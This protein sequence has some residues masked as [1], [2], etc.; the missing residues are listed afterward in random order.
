MFLSKIS[1]KVRRSH[2]FTLQE[3]LIVV[4]IVV[5]LAGISIPLLVDMVFHLRM[6]ELDNHAKS[7]YLEAQN[8]MIEKEVEGS[9]PTFYERIKDSYENRFL[10]TQPHD[11]DGEKNGDKWQQ[12]CYL[13]KEDALLAE[14]IPTSSNSYQMDGNYLI[15]LNPQTGDIY[16]VFYWDKN[17][18]LDYTEHILKLLDRTSSERYSIEV[19]YYGGQLE[20]TISASFALEQ[21]VEAVNGEELYFTVSYTN[22]QRLLKY[23]NTALSITYTI[24]DEHENTYEG[25]IFTGDGILGER[26]QYHI[27]LD[28]IEDGYHFSDLY[29]DTLVAGDNLTIRV[30][31]TFKQGAYRCVE[32]SEPIV[33]NSLFATKSGLNEDTIIEFGRL[34]HL[35]NLDERI[36]SYEKDDGELII[37][38]LGDIDFNTVSYS[39][40]DGS[41]EGSG[42]ARPID[43]FAPLKNT[44]IFDNTNASVTTIDGAG[45]AIKNLPIVGSEDYVGFLSTANY[46]NF[47][48]MRLEDISIHASEYDYVGAYAGALTNCNIDNC[49]V[50]LSNYAME[51]GVRKYY[52]DKLYATGAY[53]NEMEKRCVT[54]SVNGDDYVGG[55]AGQMTDCT[56]SSSLS[57]IAV[58]GDRKTGGFAGT[59][60][61]ARVTTSYASGKVTA[62]QD[63]V[64]GFVGEARHVHIEDVYTTSNVIALQ[65]AGG[66]VGYTKNDSV[67]KNCISYGYVLSPDG[68]N[69]PLDAGG[70]V[71]N[72]GSEE[73][74][75]T[76]NNCCFLQQESYNTKDI[77][78]PEAIL[79]KG[80]MTLEADDTNG[81]KEDSTYPYDGN[82]LGKSFPFVPILEV[83]YGD[84][85]V[86]HSI[87]SSLVYFERYANGELDDEYGYYCVT[88]LSDKETA[89]QYVWVLDTL[90]NRECIEDGYAILSDKSF[91]SFSYQLD[92]NS[93]GTDLVRKNLIV[94]ETEH[95]SDYATLMRQQ[96]A[97][98]FQGYT[99]DGLTIH[100]DF[101]LMEP[102]D[103]FS[104]DGMYLYQ[105]PYELQLTARDNTASSTIKNFYDEIVIYNGI[106]K[107]LDV[108]TLG[109]ATPTD[110]ENQVFY[111]C[112][113]FAKNAINAGKI[114][115]VGATREAPDN[116]TIGYVRSARQLNALGRYN[117][118]WNTTKGAYN[119]QFIQEIDINFGTYTKNYCGQ[120][121][122]LMDTSASNPIRN[123]P[124]GQPTG[125]TGG[126]FK[127]SYDGRDNKII[128]YCVS[129]NL[130][131]VGLFGEICSSKICNVIMTV[132]EQGAGYI[133]SNFNAYNPTGIGALAGL[134]YEDGAA[135]ENVIENCSAVGYTVRYKT[136]SGSISTRGV[137]IGGLIGFAMDDIRY[138]TS[139]N[140][141]ILDVKATFRKPVAMG[142]LIGS[143]YYG[144]VERSYTGGEILVK[145]NGYAIGA[146]S[147]S[148][149]IA[150]GGVCGGILKI[151]NGHSGSASAKYK[152][153][154]SYTDFKM[155]KDGAYEDKIQYFPVVGAYSVGSTSIIGP[156]FF[157]VNSQVDYEHCY[158]WRDIFNE[159]IAETASANIGCTFEQLS[160]TNFTIGVEGDTH[161]GKLEDVDGSFPIDHALKGTPYPFPTVL[162]RTE[163]AIE[164]YEQTTNTYNVHYGDWPYDKDAEDDDDD[165]DTIPKNDHILDRLLK[166]GLYAGVFYYELYEDGTYGIY[167][168]GYDND[169]SIQ[170]NVIDTLSKIRVPVVES[171]YGVFFEAN[172]GRYWRM[173]NYWNRNWKYI[174]DVT[175][176][177]SEL[178]NNPLA[179]ELGYSFRVLEKGDIRRYYGKYLRY[180]YFGFRKYAFITQYELEWRWR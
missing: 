79:R 32:E 70:F 12:L 116:P 169:R 3:L 53:K 160:A 1:S 136:P 147:G 73:G 123:M 102:T 159:T 38:Q 65:T 131:F 180:G 82:L 132:S 42:V 18:T 87:N 173:S 10:S 8:L 84:W 110:E 157:S 97:L 89:G 77:T 158:Y 108:P 24:T 2:G 176:P 122:D 129:S 93:D 15:E 75:N 130:Q 49:Y 81:I 45:Y 133:E 37:R 153:L 85:P 5:V 83:H 165:S 57:S 91:A 115:D 41:F 66:F 17:D 137:S 47:Q 103:E 39:W 80:Y 92:I 111:Y 162:T 54:Y 86:K 30:K 27:L 88:T 76:Y 50:Y 34:R 141:V 117:T 126:Q 174:T 20:S 29:G 155:D 22:S 67:Y 64:G 167:A 138:C 104:M 31:S 56:A 9:L 96:S 16:G 161:I 127:N 43:V 4:A 78:D 25:K 74:E 51:G 171:G 90:Q 121:F 58:Y 26:L 100:T 151:Y 33:V 71:P 94:S 144:T 149:N 113:H 98:V 124:I 150:I 168:N 23:Y 60:T 120:T 125:T 44:T 63:R 148:D 146:S 134:V 55:I 59:L 105:L 179:E 36:F 11:F 101:S 7:I 28:S 177:E 19:G 142:G 140:Q 14:I 163:V 40:K 154:Y 62:K 46:V 61:D 145:T 166:R 13:T 128:D 106:E 21:S 6:A 112:S 52:A 109:G 119:M 118:Y 170:I 139:A 172:W 114:K 95:G 164:N 69:A 135:Q 143:A 107:G 178:K 175:S 99:G 156:N 152:N 72:A 35:L 68:E 48:N